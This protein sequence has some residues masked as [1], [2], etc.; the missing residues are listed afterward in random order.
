MADDAE[1][2]EE[3]PTPQSTGSPASG[4]KPG[5]P[6]MLLR[7][8]LGTAGLMLVV[9]FFLPWIE[10]DR[11]A[12][13]GLNLMLET[14]PGIREAVGETRRWILLGIPVLGVALTAIGFL[15][16]RGSAAVG[17]AIGLLLIG[18]GVVTIVALFF[19]ATA[20]G[21][22]IIVGAALLALGA[23]LVALIRG[24]TAKQHARELALPDASSPDC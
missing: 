9:G 19:Q 1:Q 24:R 15:G 2:P 6:P 11:E 14:D 17:A 18:Y 16:L 22:W 5:A 20:P 21:R 13:S 7:I 4:A 8:V 12:F 3:T 23:G 10:W